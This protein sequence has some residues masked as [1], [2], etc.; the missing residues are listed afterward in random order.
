MSGRGKGKNKHG[1][2]VSGKDHTWRAQDSHSK[3]NT[4]KAPTENT[5]FKPNTNLFSKK[6]ELPKQN[7]TTII[8]NPL[9]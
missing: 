4:E 1:E 6:Q 3:V 7:T 2:F 8:M 5:Q 9:V